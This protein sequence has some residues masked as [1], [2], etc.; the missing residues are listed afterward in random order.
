MNPL[1]PIELIASAP[2]YQP[3]RTEKHDTPLNDP[4]SDCPCSWACAGAKCE[5]G[6]VD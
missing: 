6:A 4:C 5:G 1:M 3:A 2:K